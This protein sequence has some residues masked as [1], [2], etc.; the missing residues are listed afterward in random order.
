MIDLHS[1]RFAKLNF[2]YDSEKLKTEILQLE[3][4]FK[5]MPALDVWAKQH[6][7]IDVGTLSEIQEI[8]VIS[9]DGNV[10]RKKYSAWRGL[11]ITHLPS[12]PLSTI[13]TNSIRNRSAVNWEWRKDVNAPYLRQL[14][15]SFN[16]KQIHSVRIMMLPAESI[17]L[18]HVDS[19]QDYYKNNV[20]ITLNV[21]NGGSPIIFEQDGITHSVKD[22]CAFLFR[23]DCYHGVP[24]VVSDRIQVRI[25]GAP[26]NDVLSKLVDRSTVL[27]APPFP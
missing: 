9:K 6:S 19:T 17:G 25:N 21:T 18:V 5:S 13:G 4:Q 3:S 14:A 27:L 24:R 10:Q 22:D 11:S 7:L 12:L 20:S 1:I 16:F 8:T 2:N 23:D 15:E 26:N